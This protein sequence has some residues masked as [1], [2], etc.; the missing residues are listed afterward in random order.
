VRSSSA[1][2]AALIPSKLSFLSRRAFV[3]R[4]ETG[5]SYFKYLVGG[6]I[7]QTFTVL[8]AKRDVLITTIIT[9]IHS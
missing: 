1:F 2:I 3:L 8:M 7:I 6:I 9:G 4:K 5:T